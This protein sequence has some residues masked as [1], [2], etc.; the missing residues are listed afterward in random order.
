MFKDEEPA[1]F[2]LLQAQFQRKL[3]VLHRTLNLRA[4]L[5]NWHLGIV[6]VVHRAERS[7]HGTDN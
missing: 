6:D 3:D 1:I 2:V 7:A 4:H 5:I